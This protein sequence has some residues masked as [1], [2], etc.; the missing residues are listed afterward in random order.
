MALDKLDEKRD[1]VVDLLVTK[2]IDQEEYQR[3]SEK[4]KG[5]RRYFT[6]L[7][8]QSQC[9]ISDAWKVT[10]QKVFE[11]AMNAKSLWNQ[12]SVEQR[13][14]ILK[15][16]CSN[17]V[18]EGTSVRYELKKPFVTVAEMAEKDSWRPQGDSNPCILREREVS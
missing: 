13:L 2:A 6:Q 8:E 15:T 14:E 18:L 7:L 9:S 12:G 11:L 16:L 1:R 3:Q 4:L 17:P 5:E 10:A